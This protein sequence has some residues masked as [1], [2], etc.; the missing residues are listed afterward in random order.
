MN[1][2]YPTLDVESEAIVVP[3]EIVLDA[4]SSGDQW[5]MYHNVVHIVSLQGS[6]I[7]D[8]I[9]YNINNYPAEIGDTATLIGL[10][11]S[12][13]GIPPGEL[14]GVPFPILGYTYDEA[15][16]TT[17]ITGVRVDL[18]VD[19]TA[20]T[21]EIVSPSNVNVTYKTPLSLM[22][23]DRIRFFVMNNKIHVRYFDGT[24]NKY[25]AISNI[26]QQY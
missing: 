19:A 6:R 8:I 11:Q 22:P 5:A 13:G 16:G 17:I 21:S 20:N 10:S 4:E 24:T 18:G 12:V 25:A 7:I 1:K 14:N 23:A 15:T 26:L 2:P 9:T 3:N